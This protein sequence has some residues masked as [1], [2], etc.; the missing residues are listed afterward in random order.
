MIIFKYFLY[1]I[2]IIFKINIL[3]FTCIHIL[4]L[5]I[6]IFLYAMNILYFL[7]FYCYFYL[8]CHSL[9]LILFESRAFN[10]IHVCL[11]NICCITKGFPTGRYHILL[12]NMHTGDYQ[13]F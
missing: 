7:L 2:F 6:N 10:D 1:V 8:F 11:K 5:M 9:I 13:F 4:L 12:A 3:S